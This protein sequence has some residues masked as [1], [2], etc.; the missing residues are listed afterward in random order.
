MKYYPPSGSIRRVIGSIPLSIGR[1]PIKFVAVLRRLR[2]SYRLDWTDR[3][4]HSLRT[5]CIRS[6]KLG[7][8][9]PHL[10]PSVRYMT[11]I[12]HDASNNAIRYANGEDSIFT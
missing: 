11:Y 12:V 9:H 8:E 10:G 7:H 4:F 5:L 6:F 3:A 2:Q 1:D